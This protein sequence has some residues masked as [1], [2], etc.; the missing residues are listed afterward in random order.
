MI[1]CCDNQ[2]CRQL[3]EILECTCQCKYVYVHRHV[4]TCTNITTELQLNIWQVKHKAQS[5]ES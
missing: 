1:K 4:Q 3:E 2:S 5:T